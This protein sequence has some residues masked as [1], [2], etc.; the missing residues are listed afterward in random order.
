MQQILMEIMTCTVDVVKVMMFL[1]LRAGIGMNPEAYH[2]PKKGLLR[3][4]EIC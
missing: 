2:P 3:E 4:K 1:D